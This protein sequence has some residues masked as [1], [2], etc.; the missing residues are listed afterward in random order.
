LGVLLPGPQMIKPMDAVQR[1]L[2]D[3]PRAQTASNPSAAGRTVLRWPFLQNQ[4]NRIII[5]SVLLAL[6]VLVAGLW[7][8][9]PYLVRDYINRSLSGLPDYT[10]RVEWVRVHP[11]TASLDIYDLH[12]DKKTG[13]VPVPFFYS[14]RWNI[15]LQWSEI[16]HGAERASV[17]I[18]NP[19]INAVA[20]PSSDQSQFS[21]SGVW[22]D[23]IKNLIP[24][25]VNQLRV[26][27]G[28][29]HFL[30]FHADPKVDLELNHLDLDA[31]NMSNSEGLKVPLPARIKLTGNPLLTGSFEM[32]LSVNLDEKYATFSQTF[33]VE[34]VPAVGANSALQKY[35]KVRV[36]SGEIGL[37]S[38]VTGDKGIYHGYVKPF[39][40]NLQFEPKP[41]DSGN[42]GAVWSGVLNTVK[43]LFENDKKT[44]ATETPISGRVD[45]P[46]VD[47]ISAIAGVLWNAY[48]ASLRPGFDPEHAPPVPSDTVTTPQS[49]ATQQEATQPSPADK[50]K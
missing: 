11:L 34:H 46:K 41:S 4:R 21:I 45:Q 13:D 10:G 18:F 19:R 49:P 48:I 28:D 29:V 3:R 22:I 24:L 25:R 50:K 36:K 39:F 23:A 7:F 15:S 8:A 31:E 44:I 20:G 2:Q 27:D 1:W 30:D 9:A 16:F 17:T 33:R 32:D 47:V 43:G 40:Y 14:P 38:E 42:L 37:Y 6:A 12:I 26:L 5:E 35:L